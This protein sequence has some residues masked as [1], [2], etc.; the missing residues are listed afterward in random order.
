MDDGQPGQGGAAT[1]SMAA[2]MARRRR[3][4]S[5]A[6]SAAAAAHQSYGDAIRNGLNPSLSQPSDLQN[7]GAGLLNRPSQGQG[8]NPL[9]P[10]LFGGGIEL[11]TGLE[12]TSGARRPMPTYRTATISARVSMALWRCRTFS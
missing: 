11:P 8:G 2:F 4:T 9:L 10:G 1:E 3:Q 12:M 6:P 5:A 7:F